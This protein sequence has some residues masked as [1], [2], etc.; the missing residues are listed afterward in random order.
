MDVKASMIVLLYHPKLASLLLV[1]SLHPIK[2]PSLTNNI[3]NDVLQGVLH[4]SQLEEPCH[5][6]LIN[7]ILRKV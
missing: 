5:I 3:S 4:S 7:Y 2:A 1:E 6:S